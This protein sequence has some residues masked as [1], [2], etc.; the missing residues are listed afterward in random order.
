MKP[1]D[2]FGVVVRSLGLLM[3]VAASW[4]LFWA[5]LNLVG[6]GPGN[7]LGMVISGIPML[8]V[9]IWFLTGAQSLISFAY[10]NDKRK[11]SGD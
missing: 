10:R 4:I 1:S 8:I 2:A 6:G 5:L 11:L 9:G 7:V 3:V